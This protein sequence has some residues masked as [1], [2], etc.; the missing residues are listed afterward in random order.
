[1]ALHPGNLL[2]APRA[3]A[4]SAMLDRAFVETK[5]FL[6]LLQTDDFNFV[7]GRRGTGKSALFKKLAER[8]AERGDT[9]LITL[10]PEE[11]EA[12]DLNGLLSKYGT[13]YVTLRRIAKLLW[14]AELLFQV[15]RYKCK[16]YKRDKL[17]C[18]FLDTYAREVEATLGPIATISRRTMLR[19][20]EKLTIDP[21]QLPARIA[22][23]YQLERVENSLSEA[24]TKNRMRALVMCD[25]LDECWIPDSTSTAALG[26]LANAAASFTD[27]KAPLQ[28]ILFIRDNMFRALS[29]MDSDF[30]RNIEGCTLRLNWN[31]ESLFHLVAQRLRVALDIPGTENDTKVWNR[32]AQRELRERDGFEICLRHTLYRPRDIL[33][34][35]NAAYRVAGWDQRDSIILA[36]T[37]TSAHQISND[38][39]SDLQKEYD[40]VLP[41]LR[42]FIDAFRGRPARAS[43]AEVLGVLEATHAAC[44]YA[45]RASSDFALLEKPSAIFD[46]LY[47]VGFL[48]IKDVTTGGYQFCHDGAPTTGDLDLAHETVIHPCYWK[49]LASVE[50]SLP[51][52]VAIEVNDEY[53]PGGTVT[54]EFRAKRLGTVVSDLSAIPVG[55]EGQSDFERWV[56]RAVKLLYPG[57]LSNIQLKPNGDAVQRRDVVATNIAQSGFWKRILDDYRSRQIVFEVKNFSEMGVEEFRQLSSYL[58]GEYGKFGIFVTRAENEGISIAERGRVKEFYDTQQGKLLMLLPASMLARAVSKLRSPKKF[59]YAEDMLSKR[60]DTFVRSYLSL[61]HHR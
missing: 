8:I 54:A 11:H 37:D 44:K 23:D 57:A 25:R 24:L 10:A 58:T 14:K 28:I 13:D 2:G 36:D 5:D 50:V 52:T 19:R 26:G 43:Y 27:K 20:Y 56:F 46:A 9:L 3:E 53:R 35:L 45:E 15:L 59:I 31:K 21:L 41:G 49:A 16:H 55:Q 48:G 7:V 30:S 40:Q 61:R 34:L 29:H 47:G 4:D 39:L 6:A 33:V 32:F 60:M 51:E 22:S 12:S 17:G 18:T 1:M 38:R 42:F